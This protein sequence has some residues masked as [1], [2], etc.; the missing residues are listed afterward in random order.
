MGNVIN[1]PKI[2]NIFTVHTFVFAKMR[3]EKRHAAPRG[4]C[5]VRSFVPCF[6]PISIKKHSI[7]LHILHAYTHLHTYQ[8]I[9]ICRYV[10][11]IYILATVRALPL[12]APNTQS[13]SILTIDRG[14]LSLITTQSFHTLNSRTGALRCSIVFNLSIN[15]TVRHR[16]TNNSIRAV[17]L[18][19]FRAFVFYWT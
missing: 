16:Q 13:L 3:N 9:K 4:L 5:L 2:I 11:L 10:S 7:Q 14:A 15:T 19:A 8:C 18:F 6:D 17:L 1:A 12:I